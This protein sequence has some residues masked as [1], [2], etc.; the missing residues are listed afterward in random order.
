METFTTYDPEGF[1][2]ELVD[3]NGKPRPG[4]QLLVDKIESL[5]DGD[6]DRRQK[7]AEAL[8]LKMGITFNV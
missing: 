2:D 6:L 7:E 3:E 8:L 5:P 1:Y 4:V